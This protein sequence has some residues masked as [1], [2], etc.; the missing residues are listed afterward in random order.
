M[1]DEKEQHLFDSL[2]EL[3]RVTSTIIPDDIQ[4]VILEALEKE[5]EK[6]HCRIRHEHY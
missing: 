2:L 4:K 3:V 5:R 1:K 6:N